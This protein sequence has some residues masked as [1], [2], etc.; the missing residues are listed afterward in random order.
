MANENINTCS[1]NKA[2]HLFIRIGQINL[3]KSRVASVELNKRNYDVV[4]I[5]EPY[6]N[7]HS[8]NPSYIDKSRYCTHEAN[9]SA[10]RAIIATTKSMKAWPLPN[11]TSKDMSSI[12]I[13]YKENLTYYCSIYMDIN[14]E[15]D[16]Q[17]TI[18]SELCHLCERNGASLIVGMDSNAHSTMWSSPETNQ[19]G[20]EIETYIIR[21]NLNILNR[22]N[23]PTFYTRRGAR[24]IKSHIDLSIANQNAARTLELD[25]WRVDENH[26]FSDHRYIEFNMS[27][28]TIE[29]VQVEGVRSV[30]RTNW[31]KF[32]QL[33]RVDESPPLVS[34]D[35]LDKEGQFIENTINTA[36]ITSCPITKATGKKP[37]PWWCKKLTKL[38]AS[39][40][41]M[42]NNKSVDSEALKEAKYKYKRLIIKRKREAWR[43]F[44]T[45]LQDTSN[46]ASLI[47]NIGKTNNSNIRTMKNTNG[48]HSNSPDETLKIL[49]DT[50]FP[51]SVDIGNG[52]TEQWNA[53]SH[54]PNG[55]NIINYICARK[56]TA[57]INSFKAFKA[58]GPDSLKP[59]HLQQLHS[60]MIDRI[61]N[62]FRAIIKS[63]YT[64]ITLRK[65][66]VVFIP[67]PGKDDYGLAKAYRPITLSNFILKTLE[68]IVQW[69]INENILHYEP[70]YAQHAYTIARSTDTALSEALNT[71]EKAVLQ[72]QMALA[73]SLDCSG[74]FDCIKFD[75]A[76]T[77]MAS[78]G[79]NTNII[80]WYD[81]VLRN[82]QVKAD[83]QGA[84]IIR[85]PMRGSPQGGVLSPLIWNLIMNT[86][87]ITFKTGCVKAIGYADDIL[88]IITGSDA[89]SMVDL[90]Q[91]QLNK[92]LKW[93]NTNGLTFNP[94]KTAAVLFKRGNKKVHC[95][96]LKM[97]NCPVNLRS[98]MCY[99]GITF[100]TKLNFNKHINERIK[101]AKLSLN[102]TRA[103]AGK[104]WG[105]DASKLLWIYTAISRPILTYG[106]LVW[107]HS[108]N[109]TNIKKLNSLQRT[110]LKALCSPLRSS[111]T[112]G[113][114]AMI[115][116]IPL[117]LHIKS[118]ALKSRARTR[119]ILVDNWD[120]IGRGKLRGHRQILDS[121]LNEIIPPNLPIDLIPKRLNWV[122]SS[123]ATVDK[124]INI[125]TDG[126]KE[127]MTGFG[128]AACIGEYVIAEANGP[129]GDAT[130]FQ[131]EVIAIT[132]ALQWLIKY[133]KNPISS[134]VIHSDSQAAIAAI[135]SPNINSKIV[136]E[137]ATAL[138]KAQKNL[139]VEINWVKG[140]NDNTGNELAD[141]LAKE[142]NHAMVT[143]PHPVIAVNNKSIKKN[144]DTYIHKI[145]NKRWIMSK[146]CK[147]SRSFLPNITYNKIK[148]MSMWPR[149]ELQ[150]LSYIITGHGPF[151]AHLGKWT[152]ID[153]ITCDYCLESD[154]TS[155]HLWN[156]CPA[157]EFQ[158]ITEITKD[159]NLEEKVIKFFK[160]HIDTLMNDNFNLIEQGANP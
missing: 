105:L 107:A 89:D 157:L 73:V 93:G 96:P 49:M 154:E 3:Q 84:T 142:G 83:I 126:S 37:N 70:L 109:S 21:N 118:E 111:P 43:E 160:R 135:T 104:Y 1:N 80:N 68:R 44:C 11:F 141:A 88:L 146:E 7:P 63:G 69:H 19:R 34:C 120:G 127:I 100:D 15:P 51:E 134:A 40:V 31:P 29:S 4:L 147:I 47:K 75:S 103:A 76:S 79:I 144:I 36:F 25:D 55:L 38:R 48:V 17:L 87:L 50:H 45:D 59:K 53:R 54:D 113:L 133:N 155:W 158:R 61:A 72:G 24:D 62:L 137:C 78:M 99:L 119:R 82:R 42:S 41:R 98:D 64:P 149:K 86:L 60:S 26:S 14:N 81:G 94:T 108:I 132:D 128:W 97:N 121:E 125:Y 148:Y 106:S 10:P 66:K 101:K 18:L 58:A 138:E 52:S 110:I 145:W 153:N 122:R 16:E 156:E 30:R 71:I 6:I 2:S 143:G 114:E 57:A 140:H 102:I 112:S 65:M 129:L 56:V 39:I 91:N 28:K 22:G 90:M 124:N 67:K 116:L 33:T 35:D 159:K 117:D 136:L 85:K 9:A 13:K 152:N 150:L 131:A 8:K 23:V 151:K 92:V 74:A 95:K 77:A 123:K 32:S 12:A 5:T 139:N 115:G 130:V 20:S 27:D 46:I